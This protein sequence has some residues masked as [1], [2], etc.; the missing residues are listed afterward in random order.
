MLCITDIRERAREAWSRDW[1]AET[2]TAI[3]QA[4]TSVKPAAVHG[5]NAN[6]R[7]LLGA[8]LDCLHALVELLVD[9]ERLLRQPVLDGLLRHGRAVEVVQPVDVALGSA[10]AVR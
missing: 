2:S 8:H 6:T 4:G 10:G 1:T 5:A 3:R 9:L 7:A